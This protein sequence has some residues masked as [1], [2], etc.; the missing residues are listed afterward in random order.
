MLFMAG[1]CH[2]Q[3]PT[4]WRNFAATNSN[5]G[6]VTPGTLKLTK[7][8]KNNIRVL[9]LDTAGVAVDIPFDTLQLV[10]NMVD[11]I[12]NVSGTYPNSAAV[13][14][15]LLSK[16]DADVFND[17]QDTVNA[18][19]DTSYQ[20]VVNA[21]LVLKMDTSY[22]ST[23]LEMLA[24]SMTSGRDYTDNKFL[25]VVTG[26]NQG[27]AITSTN[28]GAHVAGRVWSAANIT[29]LTEN[30]TNFG[31]T[32]D[33]YETAYFYDNG[34]SY[35]KQSIPI[36]ELI[37]AEIVAQGLINQTTF[38]TVELPVLGLNKV[39]GIT[40]SLGT[41]TSF[42]SAGSTRILDSAF[43]GSGTI[44]HIQFYCPDT[45]NIYF[46]VFRNTGTNTYEMVATQVIRVGTLG[47]VDLDLNLPIDSGT[48]FGWY[49]SGS[50]TN[51]GSIGYKVGSTMGLR[52]VS[53]N[54][55]TSGTFAAPTYTEIY[56]F[57]LS[58]SYD[59]T[60][61][62]DSQVF[63]Y[64]HINPAIY[65]NELSYS[66]AA[67]T[68]TNLMS[69]GV[70]TVDRLIK[71]DG[72]EGALAGWKYIT[73]P[74]N[75]YIEK[76]YVSDIA[77]RPAGL[78]ASGYWRFLNT[79]GAVLSTGYYTTSM[80]TNY[81]IPTGAV[82]FQI[83]IQDPSTTSSAYANA[84]ISYKG[85]LVTKI[86]GVSIGSSSGGGTSYNQSLNT[87]DDVQFKSITTEGLYLQNLPVGNGTEPIGLPLYGMWIDWDGVTTSGVLKV[88]MQ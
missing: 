68:L 59:K 13:Y 47:T 65:T 23:V 84:V 18:K 33:P 63:P 86:G 25:S 55:T 8:K 57:N 81:V 21:M 74:V 80:D 10:S 2:A 50:N 54:I 72:T 69:T 60:V 49:S 15:E 22:A 31:L 9:Y 79:A 20:S 62:I 51:T 88:K 3:S 35:D 17:L 87:T 83:D 19:M 1:I 12:Q 82:S 32:L 61:A 56:G 58:I 7:Y 44:T 34:T 5:E 42:Q 6:S 28:P 46:K 77:I 73:V 30:Y 43:T 4:V 75:D 27:F 24:D 78:P 76:I 38:E 48:Y 36:P 26:N 52:V 67:D 14:T 39:K 53:G 37:D 71:S 45:N 29:G 16:V 66:G 11:N 64:G 40:G 70:I 41:Y 85:A